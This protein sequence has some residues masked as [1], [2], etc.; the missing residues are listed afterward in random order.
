MKLIDADELKKEISKR[1]SQ[2]IKWTME[3]DVYSF[4]ADEIVEMI[5]SVPTVVKCGI[6]SEGLPLVD[7]TP[8]PQGKW[9][10]TGQSFINPNKF[11]NYGCSVCHY[12]LDEH[13]REKP[14]FCPNCGADMRG[15]DK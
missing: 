10:R 4:R 14:N 8:R 3:P 6:T 7:L 15:V 12:E 13:I 11:I 2:K 9:Y 5:D 1:I